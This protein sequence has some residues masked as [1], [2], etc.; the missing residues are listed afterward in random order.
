VAEVTGKDVDLIL[1]EM[2]LALGRQY[3][4]IFYVK[5]DVRVKSIIRPPPSKRIIQ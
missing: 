3:Q 4:H 5:H 1:D 2:P